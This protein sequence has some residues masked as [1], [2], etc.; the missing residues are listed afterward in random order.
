MIFFLVPI[1]FVF[2]LLQFNDPDPFLWAS[3]YWGH[4]LLLLL[5]SKKYIPPRLMFFIGMCSLLACI[6]LWPSQFYGIAGDMGQHLEIEEARESL[7]F[8]LISCSQLGVA[9][10]QSKAS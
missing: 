8:L 10:R 3:I 9:W 1:F 5:A 4:T 6:S 7:G 2:G